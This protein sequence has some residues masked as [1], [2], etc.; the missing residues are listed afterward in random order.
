MG[1]HM[2]VS[3]TLTTVLLDLGGVLVWTRWEK[4]AEPLAETAGIKPEEVMEAV[5]TGDAHYPFMRGEIDPLEFHRR[6]S[7]HVGADLEADRF[8]EAW[9]SIIVPNEEIASLVAKLGERYRL[10][11]AS[12]TD[13]LHYARSVDTQPALKRFDEAILSY[14]L[15]HCK[16]DTAFF[17][18]GLERLS[19]RT[20]ECIFIDD[21]L[22]NVAAAQSLG[23]A[24]I[25]FHDTRQL[26][27]E[28]NAAGL[29]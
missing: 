25:Q 7:R 17:R 1:M 22:E 29:L 11:V 18:L 23:I 26:W 16:P 6:L 28:L 14:E 15:G 20:E 19:L 12:N 4:F 3:G 2:S 24:A 10:V 5:V 27:S 21:T 13:V 9:T 8:F